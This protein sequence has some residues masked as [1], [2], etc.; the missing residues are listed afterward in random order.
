MVKI[1]AKAI[2]KIVIKFYVSINSATIKVWLF[3]GGGLYVV[4]NESDKER[5]VVSGVVSYGDGCAQKNKPGVYTRT[6]YYLDW[7]TSNWKIS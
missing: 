6:A 3:S 1:H 5:Y 7:I 2:G 4:N